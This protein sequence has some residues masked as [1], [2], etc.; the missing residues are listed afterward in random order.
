M[1]HFSIKSPLR[2]P[3]GKSR[4]IKKLYPTFPERMVEYREPFF[5]GGS[6]GLFLRQSPHHIYQNWWVNDLNPNL[7]HFWS[8]LQEN[9]DSVV[10]QVKE[11]HRGWRRNKI[12][13]EY[14]RESIDKM[15]DVERAA[16]YFVLNRITFSG[17]TESGGFSK[18]SYEK[19]FTPS[20]ID[21]LVEVAPLLKG[22]NF[23]NQDYEDVVSAEGE[24]VFIFL[25]PPYASATQS[26]Y[27]KNG[28]LHRGFDHER[29]HCVLDAT[30]HHWVMTYDD[31]PLIRSLYANDVLC[32]WQLIYG[33]R[34][35][36]RDRMGNELLI[37][38]R[39]I[40]QFVPPQQ[41]A[42]KL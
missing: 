11:W 13:F 7:F 27:G 12:L 29:L 26:L 16:A 9:P 2:Y 37:S 18:D 17:A 28:T 4:A 30:P 23:T 22:V 38:N 41:V 35:Q 31:C 24:N 3:G 39:P 21:R 33:M 14:L 40:P 36:N 5:G 32:E 6:V 42:L 8:M 15:G 34:G 1:R 10:S 25:D 20:S 19:K